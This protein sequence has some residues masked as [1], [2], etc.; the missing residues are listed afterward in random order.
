M[1]STGLPQPLLNALLDASKADAE[2][3]NVIHQLNSHF[4][5]ATSFS[6]V[7]AMARSACERNI[8]RAACELLVSGDPLGWMP[9]GLRSKVNVVDT[10][11]M[12]K[13]EQE[14]MMREHAEVGGG[15]G[16][17]GKGGGGGG[18]DGGSGGS[19]GGNVG[20][21]DDGEGGGGE[22]GGGECGG[23]EGGD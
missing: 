20:G 17:G 15:K 18:S 8:V 7:E 5:A 9:A 12:S 10:S 6:A 23:G 13:E 1:A 19:D 14:R 22:G 4:L 11:K 2:K 3:T 16:G 21:G